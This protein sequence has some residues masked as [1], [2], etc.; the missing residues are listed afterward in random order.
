MEAARAQNMRHDSRQCL[1]LQLC[2]FAVKQNTARLLP[3]RAADEA[4]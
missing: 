2:C 1:R 4:F 3:C